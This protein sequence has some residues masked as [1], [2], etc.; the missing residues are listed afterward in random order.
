M[1]RLKRALLAGD[2]EA[3]EEELA[4]FTGSVL[5]YYDVPPRHDSAGR[6]DTA[7]R[8]TSR[9]PEQ[10]Y[11]AF[12][13]GLLATLEPDY[14]VRSNRESGQGRPDVMLRP[15]RPGM[16][17]VLLELK[18]ARAG[19]T[20]LEQALAEGVRQIQE[21]DYGSELRAA[22]ASRVHGLAIAFD[23]KHVRVA[24]A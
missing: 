9:R 12:V 3:L 14:E 2:A 21:R 5:S 7:S 24:G 11:H 20:T 13:I 22:G 18:V 1:E 16:P 23:G 19:K 10:V 17:G 8:G 15:K 6:D 4:A